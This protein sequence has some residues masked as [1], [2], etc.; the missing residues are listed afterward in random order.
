MVNSIAAAANTNHTMIPEKPIPSRLLIIKIGLTTI[1][2]I[3][4][5]LK[6]WS[7]FAGKNALFALVARAE[8]SDDEEFA[9]VGRVVFFAITEK[10]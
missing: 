9:V 6:V 7:G 1:G 2:M 5:A 3:I 8:R 4:H 10:K